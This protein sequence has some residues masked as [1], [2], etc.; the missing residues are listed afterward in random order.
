MKLLWSK[1]LNF[2]Y[3]AGQNWRLV[4]LEIWHDS[5]GRWL[6][7]VGSILL[8]ISWVLSIWLVAIGG[9]GLLI[10]HYNI[11]FGIDLIGSSA[12]AYWLA[13]GAT[14]AAAL[15][16]FLVS[17]PYAFVKQLRLTVLVGNSAVLILADL[18]LA[19]LLL[20]NYR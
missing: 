17:L 3:L 5:I 6:T 16:S 4:W 18:A 10:L 7:I 1:I 15:N 11:H 20:I 9:D 19:S 8:M 14:V 2:F 12:S 13:F